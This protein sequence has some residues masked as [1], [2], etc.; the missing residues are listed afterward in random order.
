[1]AHNDHGIR[2]GT[3]KRCWAMVPEIIG[4]SPIMLTIFR[5]NPNSPAME[6]TLLVK[7]LVLTL[8]SC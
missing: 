1:M 5:K 4:N 8:F 7:S 3:E 2:E 6:S